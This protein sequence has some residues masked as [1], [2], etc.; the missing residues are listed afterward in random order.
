MPHTVTISGAQ[1]D[2]LYTILLNLLSGFG[3]L[4]NCYEHDE[5][6]FESCYRLGRRM[7]DC[8]R[9]IVDGGFGWGDTT[10]RNTVVL[11]LPP[12]ELVPI[13]SRLRDTAIARH[14]SMR[15]EQAEKQS[16]WNEVALAR[17]ACSAALDQLLPRGE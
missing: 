1:R 17:D 12:D 8:L 3:D 13:L 4:E 6:D 10:G 11:T 14:E 9:L 5:P 7:C 16:E 2:A 15:P